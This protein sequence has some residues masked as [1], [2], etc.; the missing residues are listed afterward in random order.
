MNGSFQALITFGVILA[1]AGT[2]VMFI[3]SSRLL[4]RGNA[5]PDWSRLLIA[6]FAWIVMGVSGACLLLCLVGA[7]FQLVS[8]EYIATA[9]IFAAGLLMLVAFACAT[10]LFRALPV[11]DLP[12]DDDQAHANR[13]TPV[14]TF[15]WLVLILGTMGLSLIFI[16]I[17]F[18]FC[19]I[20]KSARISRQSELLWTLAVAVEQ[21]LPLQPEVEAYA[22]AHGGVT[23]S[24]AQRLADLLQD[25]CSL[26]G[27]LELSRGLLPVST[28]LQIRTGED[29]GRLGPALRS[30]ALQYTAHHQLGMNAFASRSFWLAYCGVFVIGINVLAFVCY[31]IVPKFKRIFSDF[32]FELPE[33]TERVIR[34]ADLGAS[35]WFLWTALPG[36]VIAIFLA[37][38]LR[39]WEWI[40]AP[41]AGRL[42]PR[43]YGPT[44]LR[45]LGIAA[46]AGRPLSGVCE[47]LVDGFPREDAKRRI[48]HV[49]DAIETGGS[50]WD[51][52]RREQLIRDRD[53]ELL[54]VAERI[55]NL[56]WA[57]R[58][59]ADSIERRWRYRWE[60]VQILLQVVVV[61][62]CGAGVLCF[63]VAFFLPL[64]DL[65]HNMVEQSQ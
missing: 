44:T 46:E 26:A 5:A 57:L 24:R 34:I 65:L 20:V 14:E 53:A 45:C 52:L 16:L 21:R 18:V 32:G 33:F 8:G 4:R 29:C 41:L 51:A 59:S 43:M 27:A 19:D 63:A 7:V 50:C 47:T 58:E 56:A 40:T 62:I 49:Q 13:L 54:S 12:P 28:V 55:G 25:G 22:L 30:A 10:V 36:A 9:A 37:N 15:G 2:G 39:N 3:V 60:S 23:R 35:Y 38:V 11:L 61:V 48:E 31:Y 42:F 1:V 17:V 6:T 64:V